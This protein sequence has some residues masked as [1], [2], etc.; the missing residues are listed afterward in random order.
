MET[1]ASSSG[2]QRN[3]GIPLE[4][5]VSEIA[6]F[7]LV[8]VSAFENPVIFFDPEMKNN[9]ARL[10]RD[11]ERHIL[12]AV[13]DLAIDMALAIR[14]QFWFDDK[15]DDPSS[16]FSMEKAPERELNTFLR[17]MAKRLIDVRGIMPCLEPSERMTPWRVRWTIWKPLER[18][19]RCAGFR[20]PCPWI[21]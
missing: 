13:P 10:W 5:I 1:N 4:F 2:T 19:R 3:P 7:P 20:L 15:Q 17:E 18:T 8:S 6:S 16:V 21:F 9:T 14:D 11:A 12:K